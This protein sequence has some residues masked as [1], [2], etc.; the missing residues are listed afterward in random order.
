MPEQSLA[1]KS[2]DKPRSAARPADT[3]DARSTARATVIAA[4]IGAM[5]T[6]IAVAVSFFLG[7]ITDPPPSAQARITFP[8]PASDPS[9]GVLVS[10][11]CVGFSGDGEAPAGWSI[12][13][14]AS[15]ADLS[16]K[17]YSL[18]E[19]SPLEGRGWTV[20]MTLGLVDTTSA[21]DVDVQ[22]FFMSPEA[23]ALMR[24]FQAEPADGGAYRALSAL[25]SDALGVTSIR[26]RIEAD[27][28]PTDCT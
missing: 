24:S 15:S 27:A 18:F 12:W 25:P 9:Q 26:I 8:A 10:T 11:R 16:G 17:A 2:T 1:K 22:F 5:A 23:S 21:Q 6:I 13:G 4:G 14:V 28:D 19:P 7:R 3:R 20:R